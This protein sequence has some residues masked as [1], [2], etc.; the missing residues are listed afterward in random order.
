MVVISC[1]DVFF[2][3]CFGG[4][5][6]VSCLDRFKEST[7]TQDTR[8][9]EQR[10]RDFAEANA[11]LGNYVASDLVEWQAADALRDAREEIE[12]WHAA[13]DGLHE[14]QTILNDRAT[15][16][17]AALEEMRTLLRE[18]W[19][20]TNRIHDSAPWPQKYAAPYGPIA[21]IPKALG[22]FPS[23]PDAEKE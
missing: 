10:L 3:E 14:T 18:I 16:A 8:E 4:T 5:H 11:R 2:L 6:S 12:R 20:E 1:L 21:K 15:S 9:L 23:P 19:D 13:V 7:M 22:L 17:E